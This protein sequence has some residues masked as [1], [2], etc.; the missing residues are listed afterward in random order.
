MRPA[1]AVG[2][3]NEKP[4]VRREVSYRSQTR[5]LTVLSPLSADAFVRSS[6]RMEEVD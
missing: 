1:K 5:S 4:D 3:S 6:F 2:S